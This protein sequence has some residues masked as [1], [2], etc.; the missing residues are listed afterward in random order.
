[1]SGRP[2]VL[3]ETS[4]SAVRASAFEVAVLPW[5]ATEAHNQHLPYGTDNLETERIAQEAAGIAHERGA[6]V[7]VL[8]AM[9]YGVNAQQLDIPL[10]LNVNPS[11]QALVLADLAH[12][13]EP[14]VRKLLILNGHGGNDF[15]SMIRELQP[16]TP[17]F[18]CTAD[19]YRAVDPTAWFDEPGDHAGE[20]ETSLL[21]HLAPELV[22]PRDAW[23]AGRERRSR[24]TAVREGWVWAPRRWTQVTEDTG[25]GDPSAA[26]AQKGATYF[27]AVVTKLADFLAELSALDPHHLYD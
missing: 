10:T 26:T 22:E 15:R 3:A 14:F 21:L 19:W 17:L 12:S 7:I 27:E 8:P 18:L 2:W 4:W 11:T 5:G 20:L 13:L 23:G 9:P 1:M 6:K 25:V 16:R 24:L